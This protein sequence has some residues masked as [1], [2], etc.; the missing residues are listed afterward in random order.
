VSKKLKTYTV[1]VWVTPADKPH[2]W[3]L[4]RKMDEADDKK[5]KRYAR[6]WELG[7]YKTKI[8]TEKTKG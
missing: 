3:A 1:W 5:S 2:S 6:R 4:S 8:E 7:G